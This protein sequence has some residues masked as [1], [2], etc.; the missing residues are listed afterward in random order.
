M[1]IGDA[2]KIAQKSDDIKA[3]IGEG[4]F[5]NSGMAFLEAA[6]DEV[7]VWNLTYYEPTGNHIAQIVVE[8]DSAS[9]KEKGTPIHP[10]KLELKLSD[11]KTDNVKM[12]KKARTEFKKYNQPIS[13]IILSLQREGEKKTTWKVNFITKMLFLIS[14]TLDAKTGKILSSESHSLAK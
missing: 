14:I 12:I 1:K 13:Q 4:Y 11:I 2:V 8:D 10:T 3:L 7:T 9:I 6:D 5:L